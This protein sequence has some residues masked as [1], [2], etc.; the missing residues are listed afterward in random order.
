MLIFQRT[1]IFSMFERGTDERL[2]KLGKYSIALNLDL[3]YQWELGIYLIYIIIIYN[4]HES[5]IISD[6]LLNYI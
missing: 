5:C 4:I 3:K 1:E 6:I 2:V